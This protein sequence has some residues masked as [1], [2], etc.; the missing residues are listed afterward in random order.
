MINTKDSSGRRGQCESIIFAPQNLIH[1]AFLLA[2]EVHQSNHYLVYLADIWERRLDIADFNILGL[3]Y[4]YKVPSIF[5][6][7]IEFLTA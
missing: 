3:I 6:W 2:R 7:H 5:F 4:N 1:G